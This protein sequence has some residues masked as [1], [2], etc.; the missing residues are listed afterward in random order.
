M[1][2][3]RQKNESMLSGSSGP[4]SIL[5]LL[6]NVVLR[7]THKH[8]H[9]SKENKGKKAIHALPIFIVANT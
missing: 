5:F 7:V 6:I 8:T 2:L 3:G 4:V 1:L 9:T